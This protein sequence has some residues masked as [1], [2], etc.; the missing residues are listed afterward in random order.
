MLNLRLHYKIDL[1]EA[2]AMY[3]PLFHTETHK[4]RMIG[5]DLCFIIDLLCYIVNNNRFPNARKYLNTCYDKMRVC[6]FKRSTRI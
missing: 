1:G 2:L 5:P 3:C 6:V 4:K